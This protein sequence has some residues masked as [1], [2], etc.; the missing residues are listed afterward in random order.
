VG[1]G[2]KRHKTGCRTPLYTTAGA[3]RCPAFM[4]GVLVDILLRT[5]SCGGGSIA[6]RPNLSI[7]IHKMATFKRQLLPLPT[8]FT[9]GN[10]GLLLEASG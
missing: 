3:T 8:T 10:R 7:E 5:A 6:D 4:S 1:N 2:A 9:K